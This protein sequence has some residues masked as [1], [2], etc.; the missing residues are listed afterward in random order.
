M[1]LR[2]QQYSQHKQTVADSSRMLPSCAQGCN[3]K[4][5]SLGNRDLAFSS[6]FLALSWLAS[7]RSSDCL[8][9][10]LQMSC[11]PEL[12]QYIQDTLHC[13]K[14]LLEKV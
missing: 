10:L 2:T 5:C 11:H 1:K 9:S 8:L 14:P 12:N 6:S 7:Q 4:A 3:T 13:V